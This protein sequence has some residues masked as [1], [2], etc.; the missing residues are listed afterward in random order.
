MK[1]RNIENSN[2]TNAYHI[3]TGFNQPGFEIISLQHEKSTA[4]WDVNR[5][6]YFMAALWRRETVRG[7][8]H[9]LSFVT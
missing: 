3:L 7:T 4:R 9:S 5:V 2:F 8:Y 1:Y 6:E